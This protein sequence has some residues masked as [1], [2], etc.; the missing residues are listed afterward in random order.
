MSLQA[1]VNRFILEECISMG[2]FVNPRGNKELSGFTMRP[3]EAVAAAIPDTFKEVSECSEAPYRMVWTSEGDRAIITYCEG[4]VSVI[5]ALDDE[6][7]KAEFAAH[8]AFYKKS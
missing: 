8:N 5:L 6:H 2:G 1:F 7:Y 3:V 4:D